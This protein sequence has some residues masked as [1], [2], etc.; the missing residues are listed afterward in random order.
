MV[1]RVWLLCMVLTACSGEPRVDSGCA[2]WI[3]C[4][5]QAC[6]TLQEAANAD[7]PDCDCTRLHRA[8]GACVLR[9]DGTC[10]WR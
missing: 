10:E 2:V 7:P 8:P 1:D 9:D 3:D 6:G 5:E 4:C